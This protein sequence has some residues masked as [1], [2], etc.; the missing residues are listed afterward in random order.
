MEN[1]IT[2]IL[3]KSKR[4]I[5]WIYIN[6]TG[7]NHCENQINTITYDDWNI[8]DECFKDDGVYKKAINTGVNFERIFQSKHPTI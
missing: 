5:E 1:K 8:S 3:S 7:L 4:A 2:F 6:I